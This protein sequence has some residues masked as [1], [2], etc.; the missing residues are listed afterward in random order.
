MFALSD[1]LSYNDILIQTHDNPDPDAIG[2]AFALYTY[3]MQNGKTPAII[4]GGFSKIKKPNLINMV[5]WLEIPIKYAKETAPPELLICVDC[6][7]GEGNVA[8]FEAANVAVIDHHIQAMTPAIGVIQSNLGACATLMCDLLNKEGF[9]FSAHKNVATALYYGLYT[10]TAGLQEIFHPQDRDVRDYLPEFCDMRVAA[11]LRNCNLTL[12][13]LEIAGVALLRNFNDYDKRYAIFK[14]EYCDPNILGFISDIA[15]QV[16]TVD[17]CVVI[18]E[19]GNGAKLSVRSCAREIMANEFAGYVANGVGGG[20]GHR[21]KA[22]GFIQKKS[23]E[24]MG[25]TV[26]EYVIRKTADYFNSYDVINAAAHDIDTSNM[27]RYE[28]KLVPVGFAVSSEIF[29]EGTPI[30]IRTL[31]GDSQ[32]KATSE[33]YIMVGIEGEAYPIKAEK[34]HSRYSILPG[35]YTEKYPYEPTIKNEITGDVKELRPYLK[36]CMAAKGSPI[37]SAPLTKNTK[38]FR[39]DY[40][41]GYMFGEVG[42]YLAIKCDDP[43]DVYVIQ[44]YI[45]DKTYS[46]VDYC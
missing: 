21:D 41:N 16:D 45:F 39:D 11:R 9:D 31:E 17:L 14:S 4:Y 24:D 35:E 26:Y 19:Q 37:F 7:Y 20:G 2:S 46:E 13:E 6:Q 38:I 1:L 34:F 5:E 33:T 23:V 10:D 44:D 12:E 32:T 28:K 8:K 27:K 3:L 29:E 40:P 18:S 15:L 43:N 36:Y 25:F 22:G 42:D 30:M